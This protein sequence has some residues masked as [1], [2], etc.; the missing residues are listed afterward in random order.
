MTDRERL[1]AFARDAAAPPTPTFAPYDP[2]LVLIFRGS[3]FLLC[4]DRT[5]SAAGDG[6]AQKQ[7]T[8]SFLGGCCANP[9]GEDRFHR[10]SAARDCS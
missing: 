5:P 9:R 1:L 8:A 4:A 6:S 10:R 2:F 3:R 7:P